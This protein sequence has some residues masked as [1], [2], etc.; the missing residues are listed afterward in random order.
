[1][2]PSLSIILERAL[3]ILR[4]ALTRVIKE[5]AL[6]AYLIESLL[7]DLLAEVREQKAADLSAELEQCLAENEALRKQLEP[8]PPQK[9]ESE[10]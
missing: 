10:E 5:T 3:S 6:P 1:M 8:D 4:S 2:K 7:L 9:A